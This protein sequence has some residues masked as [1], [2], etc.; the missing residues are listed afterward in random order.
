[1]ELAG[2]GGEP[3]DAF[4]AETLRH[5]AE[6]RAAIVEEWAQPDGSVKDLPLPASDWIASLEAIK[7]SCA[8]RTGREPGSRGYV[9][10]LREFLKK[11]G[12]SQ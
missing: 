6:L 7:D 2:R 10:F 3:T 8:V 4:I 5:L 12:R 1:M 9:E 11:A